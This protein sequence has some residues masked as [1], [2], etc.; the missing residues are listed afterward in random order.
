MFVVGAAKYTGGV[1]AA[2]NPIAIGIPN[3]DDIN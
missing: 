3:L 2:V 1:N